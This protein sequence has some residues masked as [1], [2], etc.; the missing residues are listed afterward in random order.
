[1]SIKYIVVMAL[2]LASG[3]LNALTFQVVLR[4]MRRSRLVAALILAG[5]AVANAALWYLTGFDPLIAI[6][7]WFPAIAGAL[8]GWLARPRR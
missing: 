1:M 3:C 4:T 6:L 8:Y 7:V 5:T 2:L